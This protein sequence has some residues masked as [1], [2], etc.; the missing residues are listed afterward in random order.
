MPD[1]SHLLADP[2]AA[3]EMIVGGSYLDENGVLQAVWFSQ[4]GWNDRPS[5]EVGTHI[6]PL[7]DISL[8][9]VEAFDPLEPKSS[10]DS[11]Y[12]N[13]E[14]V[15]DS[16]LYPG[17]FDG[18]HLYSV[19]GLEWNIYLVG[20]L[21]NGERVEIADVLSAPL[22][23]LLGIN[24]PEV[25]SSTCLIRTRSLSQSL[26]NPLQPI[27]YS[28]PALLFP[29][30][31]AGSIDLGNNLDITGNQSISVWVYL[32]DPASTT[33]YIVYKD[34]G[35]GG[36]YIAVGLVGAGTIENGVEV[37]VRGQSP[38]T[39]TTAA[40]VLRAF[41]WHRIDISIGTAT[42]R[43][44]IDGT[45]AITTSSITGTPLA[46]ATSLV[47]GRSLLGRMSRLLY[48]SNARTQSVM[49]LEGR[50]PIVG[51]ETNLR[52]AFNL[53]EGSGVTIHSIKSGSVLTGTMHSSIVWD[54]ASW[55]YGSILGQYAP[56]VLGTVPRVPVTW[57][58]PPKQIGQVSQ[59]SI[60]VLTE[61]QSNHATVSSAN[62]T[63]NL[64]NGT[65]TV[66]SGALSGTYSATVTANNLWLSALLLN[67]TTSGASVAAAMPAGSKYLAAHFR[68]DTTSTA[69]RIIVQWPATTGHRMTLRVNGAGTLAGTNILRAA[70]HNDAG[71]EF[72]ASIAII[73]GRRYSAIA[74]LDV[75][76]LQLRLYV[77]GALAATTAVTGAF[78]GTLANLSIGYNSVAGTGFFPGVIDEVI[79][80]NIP[81]TLAMAELYHTLPSTSSFPGISYGWHLN[82]GQNASIA[83]PF[84]GA[85]S[86]TL[87]NTG[88][89]SGRCAAVDLARSI[90]YSYGYG[91]SDLDTDLWFAA[92]N[93]NLADCGWFIAN[94]QS[95]IDAINIILG[96]LGFIVW[97]YL[98][99]VKIARFEGISGVA[100]DS[101]NL[102][103]EIQ[104]APIEALAAD[105]AIYQW[106]ITYAVNNSKQDQAN[107][108]GSLASSDPDR[109]QY[110]AMPYRS[111][112]KTDSTVLDRY[113]NAEPRTRATALLNLYDAE[114]EATRLLAIHRTGADRKSIPAMIAINSLEILA[115]VDIAGLD[116]LELGTGT[117]I[118]TGLSIE[119]GV[120]TVTIWRPAS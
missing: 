8:R 6:L 34:S 82:D 18:W 54:T 59:G 62:Y 109:Y 43:I 56:Y 110:G 32:H 7:L 96:G 64:A 42:R 101:L 87:T 115:E 5:G 24:I 15:N 36:Y 95:G 61:L 12:T 9:V 114:I 75:P 98:G 92:L 70:I 27:T 113:E 19:D 84:V 80:G 71:T 25:S 33:Q 60:A 79:F 100:N 17:Y 94:G 76:S 103:E 10:V 90:Y 88:W 22:Y 55:H 119:D 58:D 1:L 48:W 116:E 118:V 74:T 107:I 85:N 3:V 38:T 117:M 63:V 26:S 13:I 45:T 108:A 47:I 120:G 14:L 40:N 23:T 4:S 21:S 72:T 111:A 93:D 67:G 65:L 39:T 77:N 31:L 91:E 57:I 29:G 99:V 81:A 86:L 105:P 51:N 37:L 41:Q 11:I 89:T 53:S 97:E 35:A 16:I 78:T 30:T 20:V 83:A 49:S 28:P 69:T 44:D 112:I 68:V 73:A 66:T 46:S 106:T 102:N 50:V 52:E 104:S 2:D